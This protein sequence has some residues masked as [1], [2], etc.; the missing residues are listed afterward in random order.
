[1]PDIRLQDPFLSLGFGYQLPVSL[2][3]SSSVSLRPVLHCLTDGIASVRQEGQYPFKTLTSED[4]TQK[5]CS[6]VIGEQVVEPYIFH[7]SHIYGEIL[8][9]K[10]W[11]H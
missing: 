7:F 6:T 8:I 3:L 10:H 11:H 1:M 9:E 4:H 5:V 2:L